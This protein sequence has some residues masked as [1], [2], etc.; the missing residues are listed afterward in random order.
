MSDS[1]DARLYAVL[2]AVAD[3]VALIDPAGTVLLYN[4]ACERLFGYRSEEVVGHNIGMLMSSSWR[5]GKDGQIVD[6]LRAETSKNTG[7]DLIGRRKDGS[8]FPM[9]LS[10]RET[11]PE[12]GSIFVAVVR[13][14]T[15]QQS[16]DEQLLQ[17]EKMKAVGQ[18]SGALA[19]D[20]SN[21]LTVVAGNAETLSLALKARLDLKR[22]AGLIAT[23]AERGAELTRRLLAVSGSPAPQLAEIDCNRLID[24][25]HRVLPSPLRDGIDLHVT[26]SDDLWPA[27]A[28]A[29]KL[30]SAILNIAAN[31]CDAMPNGGG[32]TITTANVMLDEH[33]RE[34]YPEVQ[35]GPYV[36]IAVTD[37]GDGMMPDVLARAFEPFFTT[38][39]GA[40][41]GGLGLSLVYAFAKQSHGHVSVYSAVGLGTTVR[42]YLPAHSTEPANPIVGRPAAMGELPRGTETILVTE[43]DPFVRASVIGM[44][45][46]LG[47]RVIAAR[48]ARE[49]LG[50]LNQGADI[51][52]LFTDIVMPGGMNGWE[53]AERA[54]QVRPGLK[55]LFT[56]GYALE[57]LVARGRAR[58]D[59]VILDKPYRRPELASRLREVLDSAPP[60]S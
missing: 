50:Q 48:D 6:D 39:E 44:L 34:R 10:I 11:T 40:P 17:V 47:Y 5:D 57:T 1:D 2:D 56:S 26:Q 43:D 13:D 32:L 49:A 21:L 45:E 24:S 52:L 4:A 18:I 27:T 38:K 12:G 42:L 15:N 20:F 54:R 16:L 9:H 19:Y 37:T 22:A 31:A 3:G 30:Q 28:D 41:A 23:A 51:D 36:L 53:L 59:L 25:I 29:L 14:R 33:Y 60:A 55:L 8:S 35:P 46:E 7:R 58:P